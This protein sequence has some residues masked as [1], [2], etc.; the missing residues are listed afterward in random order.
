MTMSYEKFIADD[1]MLGMVKSFAERFPVNDETLA[2]D[3]MLRVGSGN[4]FIADEHTFN[5]MKDMRI[6]Q[7]SSR[8]SFAGAADFSDTPQRAHEYCKTVLNEYRN[9]ELDDKVEAELEKYIAA[10]V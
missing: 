3:A 8:Q 7:I 6:P 9:P 4:N 5:H 1:E 10:L 2:V